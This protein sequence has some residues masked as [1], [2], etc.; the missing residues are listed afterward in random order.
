MVNLDPFALAL[1]LNSGINDET[2]DVYDPTAGNNYQYDRGQFDFSVS[3]DINENVTLVTNINNL[4]GLNWV[5]FGDTMK[6]IAV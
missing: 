2:S 5:V 6:Q 4:T 3:W 1:G